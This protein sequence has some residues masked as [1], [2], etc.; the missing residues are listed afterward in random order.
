MRSSVLTDPE[1]DVASRVNAA[2]ALNSISMA[3]EPV[4]TCHGRLG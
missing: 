3:L 2:F 1:P 4:V